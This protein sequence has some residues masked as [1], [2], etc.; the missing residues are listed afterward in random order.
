[1]AGLGSRLANVGGES[2]EPIAAQVPARTPS[3][4]LFDKPSVFAAG[5][6][7]NGSAAVNARTSL[8]GRAGASSGARS[9]SLSGL[10]A[11]QE[12]GS[13]TR[14]PTVADAIASPKSRSLV[15]GRLASPTRGSFAAAAQEMA[16]GATSSAPSAEP[17]RMQASAPGAAAAPGGVPAAAA[18]NGVSQPFLRTAQAASRKQMSQALKFSNFAAKSREN[19]MKRKTAALASDHRSQHLQ[20]QR[21][22]EASGSMD[23]SQSMSA[24]QALARGPRAHLAFLEALKHGK[25][26]PRTLKLM[27]VGQG[28]V[29]KT[30]TLKALTGQKFDSKEKSTHGLHA[31]MPLVKT[32]T[33]GFASR[34]MSAST[35]DLRSTLV[36][37][38]RVIE[39]PEHEVNA[40]ELERSYA[41]YVADRLKEEATGI[42]SLGSVDSMRSEPSDGDHGEHPCVVQATAVEEPS[43]KLPV[44]L[45]AKIIENSD[46]ADAAEEEPITLKTW[47][48]GGQR[49]YYVM[50]HLFLTNRGVYLVT[51]RLDSWLREGPLDGPPEP[52]FTGEE[53]FEPPLEAL[54]FWLSSIHVHAPDSIIII[55]AT[56]ADKVASC[57]EAA[58]ERVEQEI[59]RLMER[60]PGV[61]RQVVV[62]DAAGLLFFPV[63]N[64]TSG[65]DP[66]HSDLRK[67]I[68]KVASEALSQGGVFGEELP[69][70]WI[71]LRDALEDSAEGSMGDDGVLPITATFV[72]PVVKVREMAFELGLR[73][74]AE[75]VDCL[76]YLHSA[77]SIVF[78][79]ED[80]LRDDVVLNTQWLA[81]AMAN[82]LNCP[83]VV[84]GASSAT[85]RLRERGE[86]E[87][88]LL[89][90]HLWK[91]HKFRQ[92]A[93]ILLRML[94]R[95]DL[96]IPTSDAGS[97]HVVPCLL[98]TVPADIAEP[99]GEDP[100][101]WGA[102][103]YFDFHGLLCRLLPTIFPKLVVASMRR[104]DIDVMSALGLFRDSIR[105]LWMSK[106]IVMDLVPQDR[107]EVVRVRAVADHDGLES[108][109]GLSTAT[110][111]RLLE[112]LSETLAQHNHLN[113]TAGI[114]CEHCHARGRCQSERH[115]IID[116]NE[117]LNEKIVACKVSAR[118][119]QLPEDSWIARWRREHDAIGGR[120]HSPCSSPT[121]SA[122]PGATFDTGIP[123]DVNFSQQRPVSPA[124]T[125]S[126]ELSVDTMPSQCMSNL[127]GSGGSRV[128]PPIHLLYASPLWREAQQGMELPPVD[129]QQEAALLVEAISMSASPQLRVE[130]ATSNHLQRLLTTLTSSAV[131]EG[132]SGR[133]G[134]SVLHI[135][136]HCCDSGQQL[137]LEDDNGGAQAL[138]VQ[139]LEALLAATGG[140][141]RLGLVFLNSCCSDMAGHAFVSAGAQHVLCC[142]G[143]VFDVTARIFTRA[144]YLALYTASKTIGQAFE[145]A[146]AAIRTVPQVGLRGEAEKYLLLPEGIDHSASVYDWSLPACRGQRTSTLPSTLSLASPFAT[147]NSALP[148]AVED[149]CGR[150]RELWLL[151]QHLG[152]GRRC[153]VVCGAEQ[154]G[155]TALLVELARFGGAPGRR[156]G[157]RV[158]HLELCEDEF[159]GPD[160]GLDIELPG[161]CPDPEALQS[162]SVTGSCAPVAMFLR[163]LEAAVQ[164]T[165]T[166]HSGVFSEGDFDESM[167]LSALAERRFSM[168][169][170]M[171]GLQ[172]IESTGPALL[173]VDGLDP[174]LSE[175]AASEEVQK[176]LREALLRTEKVILVL[177]SREPSFQSLNPHKAVA[178]RLEALRASDAARLF[179]WRVHRPL[180][181]V[182]LSEAAG[183]GATGLPLIINAQNRNMVL[184]RLAGHPLMQH[185]S[186]NPGAIRAAADRVL[187]GGGTLWDIHRALST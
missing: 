102:S 120:T 114:L 24:A 79:N 94:Y 125:V 117:F 127:S 58:H 187:P 80:N 164:R 27:F 19:F 155:K 105:L 60:V 29:G 78:F 129:V 181:W 47:D 74:E 186:G 17:K 152:S 124:H 71:Q 104:E 92:H 180:C 50:H 37:G 99:V 34:S 154:V 5:G 39:Q 46:S 31:N 139:D 100:K 10:Q 85:R 8:G 73:E 134:S 174:L 49:E 179:L 103:L 66:G 63:D 176:I 172:R 56:H 140:C 173:I 35:L 54:T 62:N 67:T 93:D 25:V 137:L 183:E 2:F 175:P 42:G 130:P 53:S 148:G 153:V 70:P 138:P 147:C 161:A 157:G 23:S 40:S 184:S 68:D 118:V 101:A 97:V 122:R 86:L 76:Q 43:A 41:Q 131:T 89:R 136:L 20:Q 96:I 64:S 38:W 145:I 28:R 51:T 59:A 15:A 159:F 113:F 126:T 170:I 111:K 128:S 77:G 162:S 150:A 133:E 132:A 109:A 156:F 52:G 11:G 168:A 90:K 45:V 116:V 112:L 18:S 123:E 75:L 26:R 169:S 171:Q 95:F 36:S 30:S 167:S 57:R 48:F 82:V 22:R 135:S 9:S 142:R 65:R 115:H 185:C 32:E 98:P 1:M 4:R 61:E 143:A 178:F 121:S 144:F 16:A 87:D 158:V 110:V 3:S 165:L 141:E 81:D 166:G 108:H 151:M 44:D 55:V 177:S 6:A 91:A 33:S 13:A 14:K 21:A 72:L 84:Q 69:L 107:P 146:K 83:R 106:E 182:D 88:E 160:M 7:A 119:V 149:F 163:R 12:G